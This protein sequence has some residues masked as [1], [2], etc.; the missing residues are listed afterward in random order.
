MGYM[1]L[2]EMTQEVSLNMQGLTTDAPRLTRW[3]NFGMINL[4]TFKNVAKSLVE[5]RVVESFPLVAGTTAY[6]KPTNLLAVKTI[7]IPSLDRRL[8]KS[9][10]DPINFEGEEEGE[11]RAWTRRG[12]DINIFPIPDDDYDDALIEYVRMPTRLSDR[13]DTTE[14][15]AGWD[16]AI[17][18]LATHHGYLGLNRQD[19]ADRWLGRALGYISS[20]VSVDDIEADTPRAGVNVAWEYDDLLMN[21][22]HYEE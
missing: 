7:T 17:V 22:P 11:P 13:D 14:F 10:R 5:L 1:T 2:E 16:L 20:R 3:I 18:Y 4:A 12:N 9:D 21:P 15:D 19:E 8:T 6:T